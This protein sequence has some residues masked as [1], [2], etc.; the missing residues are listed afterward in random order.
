MKMFHQTSSATMLETQ[1][2][3][4]RTKIFSGELGS[5]E[6]DSW[7]FLFISRAS[8]QWCSP[9]HP[10]VMTNSLLLKP[11]PMKLVDL[12]NLKMVIFHSYTLPEGML[13][14]VCCFFSDPSGYTCWIYLPTSI[15]HSLVMMGPL[16]ELWGITL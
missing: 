2:I 7:R 15:K 13:R 4:H 3:C 12:P 9:S 16:R 1:Q 5:G 6:W 14:Y 10:L 11:W 8:T